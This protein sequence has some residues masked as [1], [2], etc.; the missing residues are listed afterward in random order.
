MTVRD[1]IHLLIDAL[2][3]NELQ[4]VRQYLRSLAGGGDDP[5]GRFLAT[6]PEDDE[7]STPEQDRVAEEAR[8]AL[9]RGERISA[10]EVKRTLLT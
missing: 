10:E 4:T 3:E 6:A 1:E 9:A 8:E 7:P 2:P 5:L